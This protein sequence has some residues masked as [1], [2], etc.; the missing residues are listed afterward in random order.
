VQNS[1]ARR[2]EGF[3]GKPFL[4]FIVEIVIGPTRVGLAVVTTIK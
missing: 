2:I 3:S 1:Q 4:A